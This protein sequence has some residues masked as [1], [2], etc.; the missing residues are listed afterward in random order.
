MM[1]L[2]TILG[3]RTYP[4]ILPKIDPKWPN[5]RNLASRDLTR[6]QIRKFDLAYDENSLRTTPGRYE[7]PGVGILEYFG[8]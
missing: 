3:D 5:N 6:H 7:V 2:D 1:A 4:E 8:I